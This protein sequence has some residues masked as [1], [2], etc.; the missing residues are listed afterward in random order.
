[1]SKNIEDAEE[2]VKLREEI[3]QLAARMQKLKDKEQGITRISRAT[4][5]GLSDH[6]RSLLGD[7]IVRGV[8]IVTDVWPEEVQ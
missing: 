6:Q 5:D 2:M 1:M 7:S 3:T 8:T 4:W